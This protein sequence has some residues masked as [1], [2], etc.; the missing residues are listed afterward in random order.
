MNKV[1][2]LS[3]VIAAIVSTVSV[4]SAQNGRDWRAERYNAYA[5]V[6]N[7]ALQTG[8]WSQPRRATE[9]SLRPALPFT[10]EEKRHF[11]YQNSSE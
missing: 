8:A 9:Y 11:D 10:W 4:A 6:P 1:C 2:Y 7:G 5:Q 3:V